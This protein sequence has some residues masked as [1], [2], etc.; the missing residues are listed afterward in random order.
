ML[1]RHLLRVLQRDG[2]MTLP[3]SSPGFS[4]KVMCLDGA[5]WSASCKK[6]SPECK[7][8]VES[9]KCSQLEQTSPKLVGRK[10][11]GEQSV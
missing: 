10:R 3:R 5:N 9:R 6:D 4:R 8:G 11:G 2:V 7:R 1:P